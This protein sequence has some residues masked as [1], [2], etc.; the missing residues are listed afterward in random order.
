[1]C[2]KQK[3][4]SLEIYSLLW[5]ERNTQTA[6]VFFLSFFIMEETPEILELERLL[7][8]IWSNSLILQVKE[9][10]INRVQ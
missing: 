5:Q 9:N 1:M 7:E 10:E 3:K 4:Q 2:G 8:M 6:F